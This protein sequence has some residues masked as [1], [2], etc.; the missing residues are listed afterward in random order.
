MVVF[1]NAGKGE[2]LFPVSYCHRTDIQLLN[3]YLRHLHAVPFIKA[4]TQDALG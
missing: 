3:Q 2:Q 4:F 1:T